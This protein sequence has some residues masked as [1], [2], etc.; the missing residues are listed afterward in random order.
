MYQVQVTFSSESAN[1]F[2]IY[3]IYAALSNLLASISFLIA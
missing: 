1:I 2:A 3:R